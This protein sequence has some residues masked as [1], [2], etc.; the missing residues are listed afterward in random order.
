MG[1]VVN[2]ASHI[3]NKAGRGGREPIIVSANIYNKL[4]NRNQKFFESYMDS[5]TWVTYYETN[6]SNGEINLWYSE[7]CNKS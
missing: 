1:D 5:T 3:C 4:N 7:N 6:V 2:S